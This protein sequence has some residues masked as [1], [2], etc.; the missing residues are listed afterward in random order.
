M[1]SY[2]TARIQTTSSSS[3][4][5]LLSLHGVAFA[6]SEEEKI[7]RRIDQLVT[8]P[9]LLDDDE[10]PP[11]P[12]VADETK[13]LIRNAA[14]LMH[15]PMLAATVST[16]FGELNVTWKSG[17]EVVRLACFPAR[18][19]IFQCGNLSLPMGSYSSMVNPTPRIIAEKLDR[20]APKE[21]P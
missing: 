7:T 21:R 17:D 5:R 10:T 12:A 3:G 13:R 20:I 15:E 2:A 16:F 8:Q 11:L 18:P 4:Q 9:E 19:S 14:N 6:V 1:T